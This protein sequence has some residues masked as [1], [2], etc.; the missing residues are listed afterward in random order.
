MEGG[1]IGTGYLPGLR[2]CMEGLAS[3]NVSAVMA[4]YGFSDHNR[5][6]AEILL[7]R[8]RDMLALG[9]EGALA[10]SPPRSAPRYVFQAQPPCCGI[11]M[12]L[13]GTPRCA[14]CWQP[15]IEELKDSVRDHPGAT[16][17]KE[18]LVGPKDG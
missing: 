18:V 16:K 10:D 14:Q 13:R 9:F 4:R 8:S 2:T 11:V 3:S 7:R 6:A 1:R 15:I 12:D 5:K 17:E